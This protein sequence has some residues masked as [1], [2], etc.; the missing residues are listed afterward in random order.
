MEEDEDDGFSGLRFGEMDEDKIDWS[1]D[2][3]EDPDDEPSERTPR[4]II[5]ALGYDPLSM[6]D[7][8]EDDDFPMDE[9]NLGTDLPLEDE[10]DEL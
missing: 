5:S 8:G 9:D 3:P 2:P 1:V 6:D 4:S 10:E 7:D